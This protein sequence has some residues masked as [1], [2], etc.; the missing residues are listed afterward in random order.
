MTFR[1]VPLAAGAATFVLA[2]AALFGPPA[3]ATP[4]PTSS[5]KLLTPR[6]ASVYSFHNRVFF[7][8]GVSLEAL[9]Q[10]FELWSHRTSYTKAIST[11]LHRGSTVTRLPDGLLDD[12]SGLRRFFDVTVMNSRGDI[13]VHRHPAECVA[14]DSQ[15]V[16]PDGAAHS[17]YPWDCPYNIFTKGSVQGIAAGWATTVPVLGYRSVKLARG[18]YTMTVSITPK[19]RDALGI[20][21]RDASGTIA[22]KVRKLRHVGGGPKPI[23]AVTDHRAPLVT[24]PHPAPT[25]NARDKLA[26]PPAS[27]PEPDLEALPAWGIR[28]AKDGNH[29]QFSATVWNGGD[30]PLVVQGF[31]SGKRGVLDAYQYFYDSDGNQV[32]YVPAGQMI[33]D[34]RKTHHHW[35]FE[36]FARYRLLDA[37]QHGIQRSKKEAFC[38]ANTDAIDYTVPGANWNPDDTDLETS[39]G[40]LDSMAVSEVLAS[41]SGDTYEQFRAG[42]SFNLTGVPNGSYYVSVEANPNK[43]LTEQSVTNNTALRKIK[44]GGTP[45]HRTVYVYPVGAITG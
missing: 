38:L 12:F 30:S 3:A 42:Q 31:R 20:T 7:D 11:E 35:H 23:P 19:Y 2:G 45:G 26:G 27:G 21:G 15:R 9:G 24:N 37:D 28:M 1:R 29:L 14:G 43:V 5:L 22:L 10:N 6:H 33:W 25:L 41:G 44:L 32:G 4:A 36:D 39:C 8:V 16:E 40:D 34:P 17:P 13:V 18:T